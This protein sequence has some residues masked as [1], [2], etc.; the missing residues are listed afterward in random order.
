MDR[1]N[2]GA[3]EQASRSIK[4]PDKSRNGDH[5]LIREME[6][7]V[8]VLTVADG[9]GSRPCDWRA[10]EVA[11][12]TAVEGIEEASGPLSSQVEEGIWKAHWTVGREAGRCEGMLAAI[13][14]AAWPR[15]SDEIVF[16][17]VGD[18]RVYRVYPGRIEQVTEDDM[19]TK[20]IR[21]NTRTSL[22]GAPSTYRRDF[23]TQALGGEYRLELQA[24]SVSLPEGAGLVLASDGTYPLGGFRSK[25]R[26]VFE[27][28]D[29]HETLDRWFDASSLNNQDDATLAALR[30]SSLSP[31][32]RERCLDLLEQQTD[33][34]ERGLHA[35]LMLR[36]LLEE[37]SRALDASDKGRIKQCVR[38]IRRFSTIPEQET[39]SDLLDRIAEHPAC[40][41]DTFERALELAR[42]GT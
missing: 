31:D 35:H 3:Y 8:I 1:S 11:C 14:V 10:S 5:I 19:E 20:T 38:Y 16:A 2:S 37:P 34:R 7:E 21:Q 18:A 41:K 29:L 27:A 28:Q 25:I 40:G 13:A 17:G 23:L 15:G 9:V 33:C 6:E 24:R 30:R 4:G 26:H 22:P 32:T 42:Q 36:V 12:A 39:L